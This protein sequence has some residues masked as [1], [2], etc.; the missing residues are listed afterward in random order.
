MT[1]FSYWCPVKYM[2]NIVKRGMSGLYKTSE[3]TGLTFAHCM[4]CTPLPLKGA[5]I[6]G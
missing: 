6:I 4:V 2:S 5:H 3:N 1:L